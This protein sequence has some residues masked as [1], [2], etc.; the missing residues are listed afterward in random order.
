[1]LTRTDDLP[2]KV[3]FTAFKINGLFSI[4]CGLLLVACHNK[5]AILLGHFN[6]G[7]LIAVGFSL[8]GF[9]LR[10]AHIVNQGRVNKFEAWSIVA[11]DLL[12]VFASGWLLWKGSALFTFAGRWTLGLI[13]LVV[14]GFAESQMYGLLKQNPRTFTNEP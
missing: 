4:T 11:G 6:A 13:A 2:S 3:L 1:M 5:L 8:I 10:L 9:S 7:I 14:L 12:W